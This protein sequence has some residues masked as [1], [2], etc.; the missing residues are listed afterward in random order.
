M[1]RRNP[2]DL[3]LAVAG[4]AP[5]LVK[6][7]FALFDAADELAQ[8][9]FGLLQHFECIIVGLSAQLVRVLHGGLLRLGG[10]LLGALRDGVLGH[11]LLGMLLRVGH[12]SLRFP[13]RIF[14][15]VVAARA[16]VL[17]HTLDLAARLTAEALGFVLR[18]ADEALRFGVGGGDDPVTV[19]GQ[20]LGALDVFG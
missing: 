8:H 9:G 3:A 17:N 4:L 10:E 18:V 7:L 12:D 20:L 13:P 14:Q 5:D 11:Q 1:S 2:F 16:R 15:N 6:L 19:A